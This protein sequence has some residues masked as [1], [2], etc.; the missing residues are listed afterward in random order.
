M[1]I[2]GNYVHDNDASDASDDGTHVSVLRDGD[3]P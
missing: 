3:R 2:A 1:V